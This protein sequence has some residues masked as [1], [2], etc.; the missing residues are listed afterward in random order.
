MSI[1]QFSLLFSKRCDNGQ[2]SH[3]EY[4]QSDER[5]ISFNYATFW[6]D[7]SHYSIYDETEPQNE[8]KEY[9]AAKIFSV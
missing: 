3:F 8:E 5:N 1:R 6:N 7:F 4:K 9:R 2:G